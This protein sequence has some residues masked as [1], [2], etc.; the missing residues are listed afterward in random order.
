MLNLTSVPFFDNHTHRI[1]VSDRAVTPLDLAIAFVHG[2]GPVYAPEEPLNSANVENCTPEYEYH[3]MNM[4]VVKVLVSLLSQKFGCEASP[5]A[6]VLERNKR[7][8]KDPEAYVKELYQEANVI[9][10]MA[11]D[12]APYGDPALNCFPTTVYRLFQMD[13]CIRALLPECGSFSEL[14]ERFD[15]VVREKISEGFS[16]LKCH[17]LELRYRKLEVIEDEEAAAVFEKAQK[18]DQNAFEDVYLALFEHALLLTDELNFTIHLHTG[19]TGNP[20]DLKSDT[21]PFALIPILRDRRYYRSRIVLLHASYPEVRHAA[22]MTHAFPHVWMDIS[23]SLPW[24][25]LNMEQILEEV[26]AIAPHSKIMLGTGQ[27]DFAE[28]CWM[29]AKVA[30]TALSHVLDKAVDRGLL[31]ENQ[32]L[33][34]AEQILYRNALR[35]YGEK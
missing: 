2:L 15:A 26:L 27:H 30:K 19:C 33:E 32:A 17:L 25:S 4:G 34:T 31:T 6:V 9:G 5:E 1:N 28:M 14:K 20:N 8:R 12:G 29:A 16:G 7:T 10:E 11:D 13:P 24:L 23:W 35:L 18:G 3:V 21:D 22:L